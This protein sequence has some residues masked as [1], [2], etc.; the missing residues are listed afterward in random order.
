MYIKRLLSTVVKYPT[1]YKCMPVCECEIELNKIFKE[2]NITI[3][4]LNIEKKE[5]EKK[6]KERCD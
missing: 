4:S 1:S 5:D 2:L 3:V 6:E